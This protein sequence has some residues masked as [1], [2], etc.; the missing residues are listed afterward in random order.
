MAVDE[1][2]RGQVVECPHCTRGIV[3]PKSKANSQAGQSTKT[4]VLHIQ[5][6][7]CGTEYEATQQDMHRLVS[8]EICGKD[9]VVG[10]TPRKQSVGATQA[11]STPQTGSQRKV[12]IKPKPRRN[13]AKGRA[14]SMKQPQTAASSKP[15]FRVLHEPVTPPNQ[16]PPSQTQERE[17]FFDAFFDAAINRLKKHLIWPLAIVTLGCF[18][19]YHNEKHRSGRKSTMCPICWFKGSGKG[20]YEEV[21]VALTKYHYPDDD[22]F[23]RA[24]E[25]AT[26]LRPY[27]TDC[28]HCGGHCD[29][30]GGGSLPKQNAETKALIKYVFI[31]PWCH[32]KFHDKQ[33]EEN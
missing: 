19:E 31:C 8:C 24:F 30:P 14:V 13:A 18:W 11:K 7:Y 16:K 5:C 3:V 32:L 1:S 15:P 17:A 25:N 10:T 20:R 21:L 27:F 9:F 28:P 22:G 23:T 33:K 26:R 2:Y 12:V 6:P 4:T 29:R